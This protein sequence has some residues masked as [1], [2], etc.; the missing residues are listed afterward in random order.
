VVLLST[1]FSVS[2]S[3]MVSW[4]RAIPIEGNLTLLEQKSLTKRGR[5][6]NGLGPSRPLTYFLFQCVS[7][8]DSPTALTPGQSNPNDFFIEALTKDDLLST[9]TF[10]DGTPRT[11]ILFE[12]R[13]TSLSPHSHSRMMRSEPSMRPPNVNRA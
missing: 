12:A 4:Y 5:D 7:V 8:S 13:R 11:P 2:I 9:F 6:R 1:L 10:E 3:S